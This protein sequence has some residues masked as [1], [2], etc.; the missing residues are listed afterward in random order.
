MLSTES[1][2]YGLDHPRHPRPPPCVPKRGHH[3][4]Q[5]ENK[6]AA[7]RSSPAFRA[8]PNRPR[9]GSMSLPALGGGSVLQSPA[10]VLLCYRYA[11]VSAFAAPVSAP[12]WVPGAALSTVSLGW[13]HA[14]GSCRRPRDSSSSCP[15]AWRLLSAVGRSAASS[16]ESRLGGRPV[17][18][19]VL[20]HNPTFSPRV[21]ALLRVHPPSRLRPAAPARADGVALSPTGRA[22]WDTGLGLRRVV[23]VGGS[24]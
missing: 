22:G 14:P 24:G 21:R 1:T 11:P 7:R 20:V 4:P 9:A 3:R 12:V 2:R 16:V 5:S 8:N 19:P 15:P 18:P 17:D 13:R 23:S 10:G 6:P